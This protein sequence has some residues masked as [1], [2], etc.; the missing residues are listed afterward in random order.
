MALNLYHV[1]W[2]FEGSGDNEGDGTAA[3]D[4]V[5]AET[6]EAAAAVIRQECDYTADRP[7]YLR[8]VPVDPPTER[9]YVPFES[10]DST[11]VREVGPRTCDELARLRGRL[12]A[13]GDQTGPDETG[14]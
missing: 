12:R 5:W 14:E 3:F 10:L 2:Y 9:E 1:E 8:Q 11:I 4:F 7:L 6:P 13:I